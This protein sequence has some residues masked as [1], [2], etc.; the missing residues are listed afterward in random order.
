[1]LEL[2]RRRN[3]LGALV[4]QDE[5]TGGNGASGEQKSCRDVQTIN[6]EK[7]LLRGETVDC[8]R[9]NMPRNIEASAVNAA[10]ERPHDDD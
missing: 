5:L 10:A 8:L 1:M 3:G 9:N 2:G 7:R 4:S 6:N